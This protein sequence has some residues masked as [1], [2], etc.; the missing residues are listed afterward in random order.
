MTKHAVMSKD[1]WLLA[2]EKAM[3]KPSIGREVGLTVYEL[4]KMTGLC[5]TTVRT[6]LR[7][8]VVA[9]QVGIVDKWVM[10]IDGRTRRTHGYVLTGKAG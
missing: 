5:D 9:G 6:R 4:A 3:E 8:M 7:R 1:A 2:V 10:A